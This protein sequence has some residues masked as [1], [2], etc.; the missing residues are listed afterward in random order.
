MAKYSDDPVRHIITF[1]VNT[2][3]KKALE[4]MAHKSG[5]SVSNFM[6]R[7][8]QAIKQDDSVRG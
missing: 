3:E 4:L 8:L 6:R 5:R 2:E 7:K 1:R